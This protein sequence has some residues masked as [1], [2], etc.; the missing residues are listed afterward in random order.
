[1]KLKAGN[2]IQPLHLINIKNEKVNISNEK[3]IH[4]QF[5]RFSGCPICNLHLQEFIRR[6][7]ELDV[8]NI[9]EIVFFHSSKEYLMEYQGRFPFDVIAD[10]SKKFYNQFGVEQSI[11]AILHPKA[12]CASIKGHLKKNKPK[13]VTENGVLGLPADFLISPERKIIKLHYGV[14]ANDQWTIDELIENVKNV[15]LK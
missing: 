3:Y 10:P 5:R 1:M 13:L 7:N 2:Q 12:I 8:V 11:C 15:E 9:H 6:K 4:I 14:H